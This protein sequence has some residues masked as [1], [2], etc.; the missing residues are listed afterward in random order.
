VKLGFLTSLYTDI[1]DR[2]MRRISMNIQQIILGE[3]PA[4]FPVEIFTDTEMSL[5]LK[6]F[7][8]IG[9]MVLNWDI[10]TNC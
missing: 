7:E 1:Q 5:N 8:L 2:L 9:K 3:K 4:E 6:T 10:I